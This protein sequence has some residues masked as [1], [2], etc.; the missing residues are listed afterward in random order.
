MYFNPYRNEYFDVENLALRYYALHEG[1][2]GM[3]C[4]NGFGI[5]IF[6][7]LCWEIIYDSEIPYVFQT[8][9][10]V[11]PLDFGTKDFYL[12]RSEKIEVRIE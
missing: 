7:I 12:L 9:F 10:Q 11:S 4:E 3:H 8:P 2:S 6:G 1:L 5:M